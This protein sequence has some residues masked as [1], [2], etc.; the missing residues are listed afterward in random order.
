MKVSDILQRADDKQESYDDMVNLQCLNDAELLLNLQVRFNKKKIFTYVG[1]TLLVVN[2]YQKI[3]GILSDDLL[4][5]YQRQIFNPT[6]QLKD[7]PPHV[8]AIATET[9]RQLFENQRN[10]AIVI[11]GESGAGKTEN[12]KFAMKYLTSIG[13]R[14]KALLLIKIN[15]SNNIIYVNGHL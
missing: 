4:L 14:N 8:W 1:P 12:T 10:Q 6:F 7:M 2:P 9:Y 3:D 13:I 5:E 15:Q 11:S